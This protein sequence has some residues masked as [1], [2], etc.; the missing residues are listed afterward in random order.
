M[1]LSTSHYYFLSC[2]SFSLCA[3]P[4]SRLTTMRGLSSRSL[5]LL[6]GMHAL[7]TRLE[8]IMLADHNIKSVVQL[9]WVP[10]EEQIAVVTQNHQIVFLSL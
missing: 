6:G 2:M 8:T 3:F 4:S 10:A 5:N 7:S 9:A 1:C